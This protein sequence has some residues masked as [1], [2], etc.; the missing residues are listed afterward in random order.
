MG[1]LFPDSWSFG[2]VALAAGLPAA[3]RESGAEVRSSSALPAG[4]SPPQGQ[5]YSAT[6]RSLT[7]QTPPGRA[8][9]GGL[10]GTPWSRI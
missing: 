2:A 8:L 6:N 3:L 9:L 7:Q 5:A 4:L 1:R 10:A